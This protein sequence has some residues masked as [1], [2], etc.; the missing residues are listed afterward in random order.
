M[1]RFVAPQGLATARATRSTCHL[2]FA[3]LSIDARLG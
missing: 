2:S 1:T 3:R